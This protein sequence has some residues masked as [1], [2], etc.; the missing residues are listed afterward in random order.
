MAAMIGCGHRSISR[1]KSMRRRASRNWV[2]TGGSRNSRM[3]APAEN[4]FSPAPVTMTTRTE[5]SL[6]S[7]VKTASSSRRIAWFIALCTS[8]R[9]RVTVATPSACS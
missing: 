2:G 8:G 4:A 1:R 7:R 5:S 3:S 9:F 6:R